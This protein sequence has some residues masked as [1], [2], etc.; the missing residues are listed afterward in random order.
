MGDHDTIETRASD[1]PIAFLCGGSVRP[2][3]I[4]VIERI[5]YSLLG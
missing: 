5:V 1:A 3:T 4:D 2:A